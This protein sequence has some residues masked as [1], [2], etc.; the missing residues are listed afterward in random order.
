MAVANTLSVEERA[1]PRPSGIFRRHI[2][3]TTTPTEAHADVEDDFHRFG[4]DIV[5]DGTK[6]IQVTGREL[7]TPWNTCRHAGAMLKV[8]NGAQLR[9]NAT[10]FSRQQ[11][12]SLHCTHMYELVALASGMILRGVPRRDFAAEAPYP[13]GAETHAI[14]RRDGEEYVHWVIARDQSVGN[15]YTAA[16]KSD[17]IVAPPPFAG[18]RVTRLMPWARE[19]LSP[20]MYEATYVLRRAVGLSTARFLN[21]DTSEHL[22]P[23]GMFAQKSGDCFTF[24]PQN[25][26]TTRRIVGST[27]DFTDTPELLLQDLD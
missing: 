5:H 3:V 25:E 11:D 8:L 26:P 23:R 19:N 2:R 14:L 4:V 10:D 18:H 16:Y 27:L 17:T 15:D 13:I 1:R 24:Q 12:S 9:D 21:L 22:H 20:E 7:R 6:L